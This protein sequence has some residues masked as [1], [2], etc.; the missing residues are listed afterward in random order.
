MT[1]S[2]PAKRRSGKKGSLLADNS[3][4]DPSAIA[5]DIIFGDCSDDRRAAAGT[6][7]LY[8]LLSKGD[9]Q[10]AAVLFGRAAA[11]IAFLDSGNNALVLFLGRNAAR[12]I[13]GAL[14]PVKF[15]Q[16][17][18]RFRESGKN[19]CVPLSGFDCQHPRKGYRNRQDDCGEGESEEDDRVEQARLEQIIRGDAAAEHIPEI[20]LVIEIVHHSQEHDQ[21]DQEK[22]QLDTK[23]DSVADT[24]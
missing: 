13:L 19:L 3:R 10:H 24:L 8:D 7:I 5:A 14:Y 2:A 21:K 20:R 17:Q 16:G 22:E 9:A 23:A 15:L 18:K 4:D 12:R 1:T 6:A 11:Q